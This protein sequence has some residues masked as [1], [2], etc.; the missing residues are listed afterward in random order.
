MTKKLYIQK[1]SGE[2]VIFSDEKLRRSLSKACQD[3]KT[4]EHIIE[5]IIKGLTPGMTSKMNEDD[6]SLSRTQQEYKLKQFMKS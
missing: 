1:A 2:K 5:V 4:V 3:K 6:S